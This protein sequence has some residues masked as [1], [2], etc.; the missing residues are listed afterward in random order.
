MSDE[1]EDEFSGFAQGYDVGAMEKRM[2]SGGLIPP[3]KYRARLDGA[4]RTES[5]QKQ[6]PGWELTFTVQDGPFKGS[7]VTD[8]LYITDNS[9]SKDRIALFGHRLGLLERKG[10]G[11]GK[12][13]GKKD[14]LD[15]L[16]TEVVIE[17][18]H[19]PDQ[20]DPN[21]KWVRLAFGGIYDPKDPKAKEP[22]KTG[23]APAAAKPTDKPAAAPAEGKPAASRRDAR[24]L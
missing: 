21:K 10:N 17:V 7:E 23:T 16:D 22:A 9:K 5:K 8:T 3:G 2:E 14:F 18:I 4:K 12:V 19:E 6:T 1:Y 13:E 24:K 15:C 11:L 20:K